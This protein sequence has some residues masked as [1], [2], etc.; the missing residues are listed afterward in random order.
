MK[1]KCGGCQE[2]IGS[3]GE[4]ASSMV[5]KSGGPEREGTFPV[6]QRVSSDSEGLT[7]IKTPDSFALILYSSNKLLILIMFSSDS[8]TS[9]MPENNRTSVRICVARTCPVINQ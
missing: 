5:Q 7:K 4:E 9:K 3:S 6:R 8:D 1:R 2:P